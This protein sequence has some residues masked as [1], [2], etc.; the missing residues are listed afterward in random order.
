NIYN[1]DFPRELDNYVHRIGRTARA[2]KKGDAITLVTENDIGNVQ[3]M[4]RRTGVKLTWKP[5]PEIE[6]L[7]VKKL[8]QAPPSRYG[9]GGRGSGRRSSGRGGR[10]G[11][12][13]SGV[14]GGS[15]T[16]SKSGFRKY[17]R[18]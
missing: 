5:V 12:S 2:G 3:T 1:F 7:R 13:S 15:R 4:I 18:R 9:G 8:E 6:R 17:S 10:G 14:S 16:S 11:V